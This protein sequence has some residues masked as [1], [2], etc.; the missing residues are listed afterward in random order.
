MDFAYSI[1]NS[2]QGAL[3]K[4]LDL[5]PYEKDSF[6]TVGYT[7]RESAALGLVAGRMVLYFKSEDQAICAKLKARLAAVNASADLKELT[8]EEKEK[9]ASSINATEN[10]AAAGFGSLFG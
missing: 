1:A 10:E 8:G 2:G 9:V 5:D 7:L 3:K 6:P 4:V